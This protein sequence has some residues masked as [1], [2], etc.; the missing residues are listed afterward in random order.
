MSAICVLYSGDYFSGGG[1]VGEKM[2]RR[3]G[4]GWERRVTFMCIESLGGG[5]G[6]SFLTYSGMQLFS[7]LECSSN[8]RRNICS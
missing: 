1:W 7:G 5:G 4:W 2:A 8:L 3:V 6:S